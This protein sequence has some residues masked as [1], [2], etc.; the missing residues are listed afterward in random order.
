MSEKEKKLAENLAKAVEKLP[1]E[2]REFLI[3]YAEGVAAATSG[4]K[5]RPGEEA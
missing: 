4:A 1:V 2:K 3:G 5:D